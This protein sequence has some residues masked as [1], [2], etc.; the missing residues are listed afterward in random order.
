VDRGHTVR[1]TTSVE[2][3]IAQVSEVSFVP[4]YTG[5]LAFNRQGTVGA[6]AV[7]LIHGMAG[8]RET[9]SKAQAIL[10][11]TCD[12]IAVDLPG[13]GQSS[14]P[15]GDYSLGSLAAALRDLLDRLDVDRVTIVGHSLGGGIAL[16]F[17]YQFPERC[18]RLVLVSSGGLGKEVTPFLRALSLPGAS[19]AL[20]GLLAVRRIEKA[21][22]VGRFLQPVAGRVFP[23]LPLMLTHFA[24]L[25]EPALRRS[26]I[27]TIRAVIDPRGQSVTAAD[28]LPLARRLPV[29]VVWG[30]R[31][32]MIPSHHALGVAQALPHAR[33]EVFDQAGHYPHE[34]DP[35]R[36]AEALASFIR[37]SK[38]A[39]MT[40][41]DLLDD[42]ATVSGCPPKTELKAT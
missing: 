19:L 33:I 32:Q 37:D 7:L 29:M 1:V 2:A 25:Q 20:S 5:H 16:Q 24:A 35:E 39:R 28:R 14:L 9:W 10:A 22:G 4:W 42:P 38:P 8:S 23:D 11:E 6:P 27:A 3:P 21:Q 41:R 26:F 18:E 12:V 15:N 36:F 17:T 40:S 30:K 31:D 34:N 13:H